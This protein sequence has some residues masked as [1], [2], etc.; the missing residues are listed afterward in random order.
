MR[1]AETGRPLVQAAISGI[2]AAI[3]ADGNV[4]SRTELF[5]RTVLETTV[6]ATTGETPYVRYGEWAIGLSVIIL[7]VAL[8]I[9]VRRNRRARS[10]ESARSVGDT[11]ISADHRI[12]EYKEVAPYR[13]PP[14]HDFSGG[15]ARETR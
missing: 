7:A 3:D 13:D 8:V 9:A 1:A 11:K 4:T 10:I 5:E 2:S 14:E 12:A 6:T 15:R